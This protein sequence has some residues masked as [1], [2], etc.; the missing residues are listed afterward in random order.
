L[1]FVDDDA[2]AETAVVTMDVASDGGDPGGSMGRSGEGADQERELV[3]MGSDFK[4]IPFAR[5]DL[6]CGH[7]AL[8]ETS[9]NAEFFMDRRLRI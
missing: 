9:T 5:E 7:Q 6:W 1:A 4:A 2:G 3:A 8:E